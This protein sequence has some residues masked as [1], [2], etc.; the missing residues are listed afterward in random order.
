MSTV[1]HHLSSF[2]SFVV[3]VVLIKYFVAHGI[4]SIVRW[5]GIR[6]WRFLRSQL[7]RTDRERLIYEAAKAQADRLK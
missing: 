5:L 1:V 4:A 7:I 6:L 2:T 3:D